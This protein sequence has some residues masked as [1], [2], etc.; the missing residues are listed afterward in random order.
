[1]GITHQTLTLFKG[2]FNIIQ[3]KSV[4]DFF[5][6]NRPEERMIIIEQAAPFDP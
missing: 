2:L 5:L 1:M 6:A 4:M 3:N